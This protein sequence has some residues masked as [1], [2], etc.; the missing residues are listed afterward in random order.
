MTL[1]DLAKSNTAVQDIKEIAKKENVSIKHITDGLIAGSIV[2]TKNNTRKPSALFK[3]CAIGIGL[4]TKVNANIGTSPD[5]I[6]FDKELEKLEVAIKAKADTV[7]DLS[8]GGNLSKIRQ[9]IIKYSTIPVGTVP[10]YQ[11]AC[12]TILRKKSV[13]QMPAEQLFSVI[14]E[15]VADGVDFITVHCGITKKTVE[16]L[17]K[18][19]RI[20]GVVSRGGAFLVEWI[21][22]TGKENPLYEYFDR[23]LDIAYKYDVTLSLGDGLRPGATADADD[24][25]QIGELTV[26]GELVKEARKRNVQTIVEGPGHMPI[27]H[28]ASHIKLQKQLAYNAPYYVLGPLVTDVAPGYD[29][30]TG[31]IGGAI[32]SAAGAD[33]L[34]YVTPAEHIHLP[35]AKDVHDGVIASRIAAHAGD[36][37]KG[38][39]GAKEWDNEFSKMRKDLDWARQEKNALDPDKF[40]SERK[41]SKAHDKDTCTMCGSFCAMREMNKALPPRVEKA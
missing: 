16:I 38:I 29:H 39:R 28:I 23:L 33:Y 1:I 24:D 19:K 35:D 9:Q 2:I 22:V 5:C 7:M 40:R 15:Q 13:S 27:N 6:D 41:K 11:A 34:C 25:A 14:E 20:C 30:I 37:A 32:A 10:I 3:L 21:T 36:I 17:N 4:K 26:L 12:E 8:T 31:A 18:Q